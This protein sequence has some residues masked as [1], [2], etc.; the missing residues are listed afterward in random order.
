MTAPDVYREF[1]WQLICWIIAAVCCAGG[2]RLAWRGLRTLASYSRPHLKNIVFGAFLCIA[3]ICG[4]T[5]P[6]GGT[7]GTEQLNAPAI[8]T[9]LFGSVQTAFGN[10]R[11]FMARIGGLRLLDHGP[12]IALPA[13]RPLADGDYAA[14]TALSRIGT[15]ETYCFDAPTNAIVCRD[16]L[17]FG[18]TRDLARLKWSEE[19]DG[20]TF[21][22]GSNRLDA[23]T[24]LSYGI[25]K[26]SVTNAA[27]FFAP[28][29]TD[30]DILPAS[31]H[32]WISGGTEHP[33]CLW[34][35][36]TPSNSLQITWQQVLLG[37]DVY[38]PVSFQSEFFPNGDLT[39]RYDLSSA[40]DEVISNVV[41]GV[42]HDGAGP[43]FN[44]IGR[45]VTSLR[46]A[47][48]DPA[49]A[50][51]P[52]PDGDG[53][54]TSDELFVYHTD[55]GKADT[56]DDGLT[57]GAEVNTHGSDPLDPY[58]IRPDV[59]DGMAAVMGD[60]DPFACPEGSTNTVY[61]HVFYT[62]TTNAPFAYPVDTDDTAVLVVT[63]RGS[64]SG[65]LVIGDT[66]V[67]LLARP[68]PML[69]RGAP[70]GEP[71]DPTENSV[72][73]PVAKGVKHSYWLNIPDTLQAEMD[74]GS[75]TLKGRSWLSAWTR[76][77]IG[78]P[79]TDATPPCIHDLH[80]RH[81]NVALLHGVEEFDGLTATWTSESPDVEIVNG[82][83]VSAYIAGFFPPS[84]TRDVTYTISHPNYFCGPTNFTQELRFCP[85]LDETTA[86]LYNPDNDPEW[87][88]DF[89]SD[90]IDFE[91]GTTEAEAED[92][93]TNALARAAVT[94]GVLYLHGSG[95][96]TNDYVSL[97]VPTGPVRRCC[98]CPDHEQENSAALAYRSPRLRVLGSDGVDFASTE[99][100]CDV[101]VLPEMPS[102]EI[103]DARLLFTTN[104][105]IHK[106]CAYTV[107]GLSM[108]CYGNVSLDTYNELS[109][110]LGYPFVIHTNLDYKAS[111]ELKS[112]V[113][114]TNGVYRLALTNATGRIQ[115]WADAWVETEPN[116]WH[117]I[118][119]PPILLL[120][121]SE[122]TER[123]FT[124]LQWQAM[125]LRR[126]SGR[127][128]PVYLTSDSAGHCDLD[129]SYAR[130]LST[131]SLHA[132]TRQRITSVNPPLLPDYNRDG[133]ID[134]E[135]LAMYLAGRVYRFWTNEDVWDGDNALDFTQ[136]EYWFRDPNRD[137][138]VING[139]CD[140]VNIFPLA[141]DITKLVA[142]WGG[143]ATFYVK[144]PGNA[145]TPVVKFRDIS[146]PWAQSGRMQT[147]DISV[148]DG[149]YLHNASLTT[150][151]GIPV[152]LTPDFLALSALSNST[153]AVEASSQSVDAVRIAAEVDGKE[154]FSF[155]LHARFDSVERMY[156][157]LNLRT[158]GGGDVGGDAYASR[159]GEP[160]NNP[161]GEHAGDSH[162]V[163]VHGY[164]VSVKEAKF[165][166]EGV[167]KRLWWSG[168]DS[169]FTAVAWYGN[170]GQRW[171]PSQGLVTPDYQVNVEHAFATADDLAVN[172]NQMAGNKYVIAHS[173]GNMVV[174]S[175]IQDH[176]LVYAK[177]IM[178]NAAVPVEAYDPSAITVESH[179]AMTP[180][181][182]TNYS[183]RVRASRWC[184]MFDE[185]DWRRSLTWR[186]RFASVTNAVNYYSTE[187]EVLANGDGT[188]TDVG[189][190]YAWYYQ[191]THKGVKPYLFPVWGD[192]GRNEAGWSFNGSHDH[193]VQDTTGGML[194]IRRYRLTDSEACAL[195]NSVLRVNPFFGHFEDDSI[196]TPATGIDTNTNAVM[197]A[198]LLADAI[199]A[200]S[201]A[202]G[203]NPVPKWVDE[204]D[205]TGEDV[206]N[207]NMATK[208]KDQNTI[209][210]L[211][212]GEDNW[213]HSFFLQAPYMVVR[214][215]YLSIMKVING[216]NAL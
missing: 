127:S 40:Y 14:G 100:D 143:R 90:D 110:S 11:D 124:A 147:E 102:R 180:A 111:L 203:R 51:D 129:F 206:V 88:E 37:G 96:P 6:D 29:C 121:T 97:S 119:H 48:L 163:F 201:F 42:S 168:L 130:E 59:P 3:L 4:G 191:E 65:R 43:V 49:W 53:L 184:E 114:F 199:P 67:P 70:G 189:R 148:G 91:D 35:A 202:T 16:W 198:R 22:W 140:M 136:W 94:H 61:E 54:T 23:A 1:V 95:T 215:F 112:D 186:G 78:F 32:D 146:L 20:W 128:L 77:W 52:D 170:D 46:F 207:V 64:G 212:L 57:D 113:L 209:G 62:G 10:M 60:L 73:V 7:N 107:L 89:T 30:L 164:N 126:G 13:V 169:R 39:Y 123:Y 83:P 93:Y 196:Y 76:G 122:R 162:V 131:G 9:G 142:S 188:E 211:D 155:M 106:E 135:D 5:K 118:Y 192:M 80:A 104:G 197:R 27:S 56:D 167:F 133:R 82:G 137:D 68:A 2:L 120:D 15:N 150:L 25:V 159:M 105:V 165:W 109:P 214:P 79:H 204:D 139:R 117:T 216:G 149:V 18:A 81:K 55:P 75:L 177:Y 34:Y 152:Q 174:S 200:E 41:V 17:A 72:R 185:G 138:D 161:D 194:T 21:P 103:G 176:G 208:F 50:D 74:S 179:D 175:A 87:T 213:I 45:G 145:T 210:V 28:L 195:P 19:G 8:Q 71:T 44:A 190:E 205:E 193:I 24:V 125:V 151:S 183:D 173:L 153:L 157:W 86:E 115:V 36:F 38:R 26:E 187:E 66:V 134:D 33:S 158:A 12:E 156:C 154:V 92:A 47:R 171:L 132:H 58:S 69:L 144:G 99:T 84:S 181:T 141:V 116:Y 166:G 31:R 101:D 108:E 160:Q 85:Q 172:L 178:L 63:V 182:W 98:G